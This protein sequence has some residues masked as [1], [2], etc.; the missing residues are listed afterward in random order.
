MPGCC[1]AVSNLLRHLFRNIIAI[2]VRSFRSL[3]L[4]WTR[5]F[6]AIEYSGLDL[7][8][9]FLLQFSL[10][11][12]F[13]VFLDVPKGS[14]SSKRT[15]SSKVFCAAV[16][17]SFNWEKTIEIH[18][19]FI[20]AAFII[21]RMTLPLGWMGSY[22]TNQGSGTRGD[23]NHMMTVMHGAK[24]VHKSWQRSRADAVPD[25]EEWTEPGPWG[26]WTTKAH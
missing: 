5:I 15:S 10:N 2:S 1:G 9:Y 4:R 18:I 20:S 7:E 6:M 24:M 19:P 16:F 25:N 17:P 23:C 21:L 3:D 8:I 13:W 14:L 11:L 22:L 12:N 26:A